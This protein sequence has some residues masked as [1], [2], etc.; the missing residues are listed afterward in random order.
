VRRSSSSKLGRHTQRVK[1]VAG[2]AGLRS[3][4]PSAVC[5]FRD[6]FA[7]AHG[8]RRREFPAGRFA[9]AA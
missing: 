6:E 5:P 2:A 4:G 8:M 3:G 7:A 9:P 1:R